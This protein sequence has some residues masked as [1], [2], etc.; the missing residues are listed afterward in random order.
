MSTKKFPKGSEW[1]KWDLHV[2][3]PYSIINHY[4][5]SNDDDKWENFIKDLENLPQEF[6][7]LGINDYLF[8]EG[9]KK[10]IEFKNCGRLKNIDLVL[11]V[12]EFRIEKFAGHKDFKKVNFHV[13]FSNE[14]SPDIIQ[15]QFLN[16]LKVKFKL[17]PGLYG[18]N[19]SGVITKESLS[20]LGNKVKQSI[21]A[22]KKK[23]FG[24]DLQEGFNNL[25]VDEKEIIN[26]LKNNSYLA[27]KYLTAIGKTEWESLA[28]ND[29]SIA[30]KK[31][32]INKAD[33]VFISAEDVGKYNLAQNKLTEQQVNNLLLDCSDAHYNS[34]SNQK[35]RIGKCFTWIKADPTFEGLKQIIYEP[36]ERVRIQEINPEF[37][38]DKPTFSKITI[39]NE[40]EIF[41]NEKVKFNKTELPFNKNL[42]TII[43]GRGTGKSLL[44]NYM[45]NT[46]NKSVLAYHNKDKQAKFKNSEHFI[47]NWQKNNNP[48]PDTMTFNCKEKGSLDFIF[49]E[50]GRLKNISDYKIL[51]DEIKKLLK[52]EELKF[53]E[54]LDA[55]IMTLLEEIKKL[56]DWF[57]YEN[58]NG[59]KINNKEFN[60]KKKQDAKKLLETI[61]TTEN[62]QKLETYTSNIKKI[63]E[64]SNWLNVLKELK[65]SLQNYQKDTNEVIGKIISEIQTEINNASIPIIDFNNQIKAIES[66]ENNLQGLLKNKEEENNKIKKEFEEQGYKGDLNTLLNNAEKYQKDIQEATSKLEE[67]EKNE[68]KVN[69]K[70]IERSNLREK[71]KNEYERHKMT[72]D[73]AWNNLLNNFSENQKQIISKVLEQRN[74]A[75]NG[76]IIFDIKKFDEKL[77]DYLDLRT[78]KNLSNDLGIEIIED[79]WNFIENKL[80]EYL[81]GK[82]SE[83]TKKPLEELFFNLKNRRDYLYV[84]PEIKYLGKTLDQLSVGQRGTLYL[85]IQLATNA[86][87]SP[88]I[89]DQPEDDLDNEFI[90]NELVSLFQELKKY[91]QIIIS[92]HNANLVVTA[93]AEQVIV[94]NNKNEILSYSS[95]SLENPEIIK[96]VCRILEGGEI[97]FENRKRKYNL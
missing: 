93:D 9:Y 84:V 39:H 17:S 40:V 74:I 79:Y 69:E 43:G 44:L 53:D 5:G 60:E 72:I 46:F 87:S 78:Y 70:I 33:I 67:I 62:R 89:F 37:D 7:V 27:G 96:N 91:R 31:D 16:A 71:L 22:D 54:K 68:K 30:I 56:K 49:I 64:Y 25:C 55:E 32:I 83:T 48:Q 36:E 20:D 95:G 77:K 59:E 52:I 66:I 61:T 63:S 4:K 85:L 35:D 19:W 10:V 65:E 11:P 28:W 18:I 57:E 51:S 41:Q 90:T 14:L 73:D 29:Q 13:I 34:D 8:I 1:R 86:F 97:A 23:D 15:N 38:F 2:H 42:V 12:I 88:L 81:E 26:I 24:S 50:Q 94:A 47:I 58:E 21:P 76:Q 45:A 80:H 3:T 92:T 75:I 82:K 6:K